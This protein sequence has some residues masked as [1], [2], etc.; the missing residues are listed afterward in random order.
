MR[1]LSAFE[2]SLMSHSVSVVEKTV[3]QESYI[4]LEAQD[5]EKNK[6]IESA[7]K[8]AEESVNIALGHVEENASSPPPSSLSSSDSLSKLTSATKKPNVL[9]ILADDLRPQLSVFGHRAV[10]PNLDKLSETGITFERA[11]AQVYYENSSLL[12]ACIS[13]LH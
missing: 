10:T 6:N 1:E 4:N 8:S 9:F 11:H 7:D 12:S 3:H 13:F 2:H 5:V